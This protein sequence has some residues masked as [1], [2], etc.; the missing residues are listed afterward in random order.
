MRPLAPATERATLLI[1]PSLTNK[2]SGF[3]E[4]YMS[5]ESRVSSAVSRRGSGQGSGDRIADRDVSNISGLSFA[6]AGR[7]TP[8]AQPALKSTGRNAPLADFLTGPTSLPILR[9]LVLFT[10]LALAVWLGVGG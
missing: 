6:R 8:L 5:G 2:Q 7:A 3:V 9:S 10:A 4:A 1:N